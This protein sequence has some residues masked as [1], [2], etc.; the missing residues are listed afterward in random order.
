M[1]LIKPVSDLRSYNDVLGD[2]AEGT[3]VFLTRNG[4]GSYVIMD[5][6][7]YDRMQAELELAGQLE[8]GR[9]SGKLD[10]WISQEDVAARFANLV[11]EDMSHA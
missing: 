11:H 3:P 1:P 7:D 9:Q 4:R 8:A 6:Q 2:V 10:G 5:M